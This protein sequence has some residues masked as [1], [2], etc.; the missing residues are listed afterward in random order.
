MNN[1]SNVIPHTVVVDG[2]ARE[3]H[4]MWA[5]DDESIVYWVHE[6]PG[7]VWRCTSSE[8]LATV[9]D[10]VRHIFSEDAGV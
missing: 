8:G 9:L 6:L 1:G 4:I 3:F 5:F 2:V 10:D 7:P